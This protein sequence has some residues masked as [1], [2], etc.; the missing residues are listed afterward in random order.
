MKCCE[1]PLIQSPA[2]VYGTPVAFCEF[3]ASCP[4]ICLASPSPY[5][6][7]AIVSERHSM[8]GPKVSHVLARHK[9]RGKESLIL[10]RDATR[11]GVRI[12]SKF[13]VSTQCTPGSDV[14]SSGKR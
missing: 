5:S 8:V 4:F 6:D 13:S 2:R 11:E 3:V 1:Y 14:S 10:L 12:F 9:F 7:A